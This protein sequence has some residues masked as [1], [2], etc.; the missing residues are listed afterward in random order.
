MHLPNLCWQ[1]I[2]QIVGFQPTDSSE[3]PIF[4][5]IFMGLLV[6]YFPIHSEIVNVWSDQDSLLQILSER[7]LQIEVWT[8]E[9][10]PFS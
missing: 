6:E 9:A 8:L 1:A 5:T 4:E 2:Q 10:D 7:D 3:D